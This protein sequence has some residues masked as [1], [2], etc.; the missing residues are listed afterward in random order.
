[1]FDDGQHVG[2]RVVGAGQAARVDV[3]RHQCSGG[4]CGPCG[5]DGEYGL[6]GGVCSAGLWVASMGEG[7]GRNRV[8]VPRQMLVGRFIGLGH[9]CI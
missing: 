9:V 7:G 1:M 6:D 5:G 4:C 3:R 2:G 8:L